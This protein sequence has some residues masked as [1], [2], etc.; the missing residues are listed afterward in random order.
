[1]VG[2]SPAHLYLSRVAI[3]FHNFRVIVGGTLTPQAAPAVREVDLR[4]TSGEIMCNRLAG[5]ALLT[6]DNKI[7]LA[8]VA[9][10]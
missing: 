5:A 7:P 9:N 3:A 10:I 4:F 1:M 2:C 6:G 8:G